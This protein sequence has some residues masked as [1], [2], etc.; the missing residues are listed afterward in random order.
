[1]GGE[2]MYAYVCMCIDIY[3]C[4]YICV[5]ILIMSFLI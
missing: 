5:P 1:M 3:V 2:F 4:M